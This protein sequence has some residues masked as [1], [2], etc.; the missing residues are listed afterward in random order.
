MGRPRRQR[1]RRKFDG[2]CFLCGLP[3]ELVLDA[4]RIVGGED[5]GTYHW[6]NTLTLCSNCHRKVTA[7]EVVI[8]GR[9][10]STG[11]WVVL[12]TDAEGREHTR[13]G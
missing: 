7:G 4:H 6:R 9:F 10:L 8:R 12:Y 2:R 3:D 5:G 11:G 1:C 13:R